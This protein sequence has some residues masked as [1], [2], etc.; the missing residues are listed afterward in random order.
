[1]EKVNK[2]KMNRSF[3]S[4][5]KVSSRRQLRRSQELH[6]K[7]LRNIKSTL[8]NKPPKRHNHLRKN[9]KKQQMMQDRFA[10][11]ERENQLLL[12]KMS[13]IMQN[14]T[15]D[16][17]CK[18]ATYSKSLN[19]ERRR[20]ELKRISEQNNAILSR[21]QSRESTYNHLKWENDRKKNERYLK[22]ISEYGLPKLSKSYRKS[23]AK[24]LHRLTRESKMSILD[25]QPTRNSSSLRLSPLNRPES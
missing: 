15:L 1:V 12:E 17:K 9:R 13:F 8:D 16:N 14:D 6:K 3:K 4:G 24:R 19:K 7:K 22:M 21:I 10:K 20:K 18:A 25:D 2:K 23:S 11:I 5:N